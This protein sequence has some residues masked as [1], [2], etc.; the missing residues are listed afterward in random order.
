M[1]PQLGLDI[2]RV[3]VRLGFLMGGVLFYLGQEGQMMTK[4]LMMTPRKAMIQ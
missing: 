4:D 1:C 2:P 3:K